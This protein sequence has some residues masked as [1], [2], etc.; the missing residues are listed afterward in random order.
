MRPWRVAAVASLSVLTLILLLWLALPASAHHWYDSECCN[1]QDCRPVSGAVEERPEG[2]FVAEV[3]ELVPHG[4][5]K[6]KRSLDGDFHVCVYTPAGGK[7]T[8][9]CL[10]APPRGF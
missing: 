2:Y 8:V 10:Y 1:H 4:S 5:S 9:R 6:I 7:Q 3:G